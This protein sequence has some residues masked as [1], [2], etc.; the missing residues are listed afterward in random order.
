MDYQLHVLATAADRLT[1]ALP[2]MVLPSSTRRSPRSCCNIEFRRAWGLES[3]G[4]TTG[5]GGTRA[6]LSGEIPH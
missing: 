6:E 3:I 4:G 1:Q 2:S 5:P